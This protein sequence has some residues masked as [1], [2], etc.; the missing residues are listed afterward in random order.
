M[1]PLLPRL[2]P[3]VPLVELDEPEPVID[4]LRV[5]DPLADDPLVA[6]LLLSRPPM[7]PQPS[8]FLEVQG[9]LVWLA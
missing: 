7:L 2:L 1:E 3:P 6:P 5:E 9:G 8:W 4:P